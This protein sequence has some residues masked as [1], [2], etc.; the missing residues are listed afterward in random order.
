VDIS[1]DSDKRAMTLER[2]GLDFADAGRV[3]VG[4]VVTIQ[5]TASPVANSDSSLPA[6]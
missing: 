5:D 3:F 2:R 6:S 4:D 1:F